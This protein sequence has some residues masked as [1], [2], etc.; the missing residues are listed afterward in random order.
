MNVAEREKG[1]GGWDTALRSRV[2]F[3][4]LISFHG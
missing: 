1:A 2:S 3:F 4:F